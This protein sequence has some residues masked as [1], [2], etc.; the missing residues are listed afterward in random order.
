MNTPNATLTAVAAGSNI[1]R[2]N[3][4]ASQ[5]NTM[6]EKVT[7]GLPSIETHDSYIQLAK[8]TDIDI[9]YV[10]TV[11]TNHY[12]T[13][14]MLI[15]HNKNVLIEKPIGINMNEAKLLAEAAKENN[16]FL[17]EGMWTRFFP[18]C[19][20]AKELILNGEI[21]RVVAVHADFG[22]R[23]DDEPSR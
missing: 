11:N 20:K 21:G 23:C 2:A 16:V 13:A 10:G 14:L 3:T 18:S 19:K 7:P 6:Q 8:R 22:F 15:K 5:F 17:M 9:V 1:E 12:E 4:F